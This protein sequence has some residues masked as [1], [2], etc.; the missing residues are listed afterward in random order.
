MRDPSPRERVH[1][2]VRSGDRIL[3]ICRYTMIS[4]LA[5]TMQHR[6]GQASRHS[7]KR[8]C[9]LTQTAS[10]LLGTPRLACRAS[11]RRPV[12]RAPLVRRAR[13]P[14]T[15]CPSSHPRAPPAAPSRPRAPRSPPSCKPV[16]PAVSGFSAKPPSPLCSSADAPPRHLRRDIP[17]ASRSEVVPASNRSARTTQDLQS[18]A[19]AEESLNLAI[20]LDLTLL[21]RDRRCSGLEYFFF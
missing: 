8:S 3:A 20:V 10:L 1:I 14:R 18:L 17:L 16:D 5:G 9:A 6:I 19:R 15:T 4:I 12:S 7:H 13:L 21:F 11:P 2:P